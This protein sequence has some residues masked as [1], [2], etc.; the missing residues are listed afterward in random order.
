MTMFCS[1]RRRMSAP[2]TLR[3]QAGVMLLEA[4]IG[5][6]IFTIGLLALIKLQAEAVRITTESKARGDAS[7][8][9]D[10]VIGDLATQNLQLGASSVSSIVTDYSG[11]YTPTTITGVGSEVNAAV[12]GSWQSMLARTLPGGTLGI[13]VDSSADPLSAATRIHAATVTVTWT[14]SSGVPRTFSQYSQLVD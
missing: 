4:L 5:T 9:A 13:A 7:Y 10:K 1:S 2:R 14:T 8:L 3:K 6:L 12:C 11:T